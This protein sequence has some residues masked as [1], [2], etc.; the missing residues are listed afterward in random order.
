[1]SLYSSFN[2][3]QKSLLLNQ[4]A[5]SVVS[6]NIANMNT[7]GYSKQRLDQ[8]ASGEIQIQGANSTS[9]QISEGAQIGN[10]V[11]YRQEYLDTS[12]RDQNADVNYFSQ[13][14]SMAGIIESSLNELSGSGLQDSI[15]QFFTAVTTLNSN[16][17]D[18]TARTNFV[19]KAQILCTQFN[20]VAQN[21]DQN[22]TLTVGKV[23]DS[24]SL[25]SSKVAIDITDVNNKLDQLSKINDTIV[26]TSAQGTIPND[27]LDQR[28]NLLD[29]ISAYMPVTTTS[30][31]NGSINLSL[32]GLTL[33][34]GNVTNKLEIVQGTA[35]NPVT[36]NLIDSKGDSISD[37]I[38]GRFTS[39]RI[40]SYLEMG[41]NVS[42]KLS[43]Q[44]MMT[45]LDKLASGFAT[46]INDIQTYSVGNVKAMAID[47]DAN[48]KQFLSDYTTAPDTGLPDIFSNK[49]GAGPITAL[50]MSVNSEIS[51]SYWKIATARVDADTTDP[52]WETTGKWAV[53]NTDNI[54]LF[55]AVR[56]K[57]IGTLNDM[58]PENYLTSAVTDM[59]SKI[60]TINFN[61]KSE[62]SVFQ[63]I[64]TERQ[65]AIGVNMDEELVDLVKY[66]RAYEASARIFNT[67]SSLLETLVN[68]GR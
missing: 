51:A 62:N 59:G 32:N 8:E 5:L 38:N 19:Q 27:L 35:D 31:E 23:G 12:Y 48:G 49:N 14:K 30:N 13:L 43:Y 46:A 55:G 26:K 34:K 16:P 50:N 67:A 33:V 58:T 60:E 65:S 15:S 36:I 40:A 61:F 3:A 45:Q 11:R 64:N 41:G 1:M 52:S 17:A 66:Q 47:F 18:S 21:L 56:N 2:I 54:K 53:G 63:S 9:Y 37:N 24:Q 42:G 57:S 7:T 22:R 28:D 29:E 25:V 44:S 6:N 68:L 20:Q 4:S 10:I 39:G